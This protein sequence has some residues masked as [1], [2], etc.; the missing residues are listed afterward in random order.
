MC[1]CQYQTYNITSLWH[2]PPGNHKFILCESVL[3][4]T[5]FFQM[6]HKR[7][8]V[9]FVFVWL[10][11]IWN[12]FVSVSGDFAHTTLSLSLS[13]PPFPT[14]GPHMYTKITCVKVTVVFFGRG[15]CS[16]WKGGPPCFLDTQK[17][18]K[19]V[20]TPKLQM[21]E[22]GACPQ[23]STP[24]WDKTAQLFQDS[25]GRHTPSSAVAQRQERTSVRAAIPHCLPGGGGR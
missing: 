3:Q 1:I 17:N 18:T 8:H 22:W 20:K 11:F 25:K 7:Y 24:K 12:Y 2:I 6:S 9:I 15:I 5:S 21:L 10:F 4:I 14:Q 19:Y 23:Q 13:L 16:A